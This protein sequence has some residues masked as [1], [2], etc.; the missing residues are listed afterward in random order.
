MTR[1]GTTREAA[2][3][4]R[5]GVTDA[6]A[7]I[8]GGDQAAQTELFSLVYEELRGM[9]RHLMAGERGPRTLQPTALVHEAYLRLLRD[10]PLSWDSR[11]HFFAAAATAMRRIL[12]ERAR[13]RRAVRHG[14]DLVRVTLDER[15]VPAEAAAADLLAL[16][17]ALDRLQA[18]DE[19]AGRV[20][21][22]R[23]FAGLGID[24][25]A[26]VMG[27]SPATVAREWSYA[28]AWLRREIAGPGR[29]A[30]TGRGAPRRA[31]RAGR[32]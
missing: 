19:R 26:E 23:Y 4:R 32:E 18:E 3:G 15:V 17:E 25:T 13:R 10:R 24:E 29:R 2:A 30:V 9:A 22:L 5:A 12:V 1:T 31:R 20:V 8:R 6:L 21:H 28:R 27:L 11:G 14:G 16:D 7:A